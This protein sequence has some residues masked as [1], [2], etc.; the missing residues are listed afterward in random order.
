MSPKMILLIGF[1]GST[2]SSF[3]KEIVQS[4]PDVIVLSKDTEKY[5]STEH[6]VSIAEQHLLDKK[7]V[8]IDNTNL[9]VAARKPFIELGK[10]LQIKVDGRYFKSSIE[11]CQ[12]R[13]MKRMYDLFGYI[14]Q[15]GKLLHGAKHSHAFGPGA[16]FAARKALEEPKRDEGFHMVIVQ[17]IGPI[18]WDPVTYHKKALF[19]DIDGTIR[20]T[21]H[22]P[23]KYPTQVE[24]VQLIHPKEKMRATLDAYR[25]DGYQL[26]GVS[27]QSGISKGILTEQKV[28]EIFEATRSLLGYTEAEFPILYCPH[29]S[30]PVTCFCRKP[31]TGMAMD[32][33]LKLGL[34]PHQCI[35]VGDQK[36]DQNMAE[37]LHITYYD[38]KDFWKGT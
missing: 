22:L 16:L 32:C 34:D 27:N 36:T 29:P 8:I 28:D 31:Q 4:V 33:I 19:L 1:Q 21:E 38:V 7:T 24:E 12:I 2:K 14:P 13:H 37:R 11:D 5:K 20:E 3:A 10:R 35:M 30:M 17:E 6:M 9:T 15:T 18:S 23:H 25:A 26:I